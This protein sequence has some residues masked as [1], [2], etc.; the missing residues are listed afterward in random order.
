MLNLARLKYAIIV[1]PTL[2]KALLIRLMKLP[3]EILNINYFSMKSLLTKAIKPFAPI[4]P[5]SVLSKISVC[6]M[7]CLQLPNK[8]KVY[9]Q[10]DG[11][12]YIVSQLYWRGIDAF[13]VHSIKFFIDLLNNV[14]TFFDIGANIG[15][16]SL[17]AA[18]DRHRRRVYA[19]EP[20]PRVLDCLLR[21]VKLNKLHNIHINACAITNYQGEIPLY[22]PNSAIPTDASTL[23]GFRKASEIISVQAMTIDSFISKNDILRVD[24]IKI[25]TEGTEHEVLEGAKNILMRDEPIIICEVLKERTE[26]YLHSVL[27]GTGYK[28]FLISD[29]GLIEK[30]RIEGDPTYKN[31]NYLFITDKKR[32]KIFN[33]IKK[34]LA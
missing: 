22:I 18:N 29:I 26:D 17:I 8:K 21:N 13:E 7:I 25:D 31:M 3:S 10:S 2:K 14:D 20:V 6:G 28:Y 5:Q 11:N 30:K 9:L 1:A 24:L 12:D 34:W 23:K 19:F 16:Y 27:D 15:I 32:Q 33:I 4:I